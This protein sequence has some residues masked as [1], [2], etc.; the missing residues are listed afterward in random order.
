L[1]TAEELGVTKGNADQMKSSSQDP[2]VRR[3]L[4]AEGDFGKKMGLDNEWALRAIK[5]AGNYG[6]LYEQYF[7]PKA[8]DLDRG[9]NNLW[10]KGGLQYSL[11][12]R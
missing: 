3:L 8:L 4:G 7:G 2:A 1:I 10:N 9:L 11:P 5:T 6:E 12:F